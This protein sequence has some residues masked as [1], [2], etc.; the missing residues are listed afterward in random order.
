MAIGAAGAAGKAAQAGHKPTPVATAVEGGIASGAY[1]TKAAAGTVAAKEVA[2]GEKLLFRRGASD[3]KALLQRDAQAAEN[4]LGI[5]GVSV[6]TSPAAR[7]G[8]VVRCA[9]CN[10]VEAAGYKV[11]QTG[12]DLNHHT[13]EL[14]KPITL[15]VVRME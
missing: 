9:T 7:A 1:A 3:T 2:E 15:D 12:K 8:Q 4:V 11:Q 10:S 14:P 5:H 13:V 6:S